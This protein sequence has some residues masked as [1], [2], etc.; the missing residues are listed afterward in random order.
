MLGTAELV[1]DRNELQ[2]KWQPK[3]QTWFPQG[4]DEPNLALLK[5]N[6]SK[7]DYWDSPSSSRSQIINLLEVAHR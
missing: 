4:L 2:E 7:A 3:L 6:I 1:R 5:V